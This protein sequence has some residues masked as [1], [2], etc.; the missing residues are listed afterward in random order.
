MKRAFTLLALLFVT[1]PVTTGVSLSADA[2]PAPPETPAPSSGQPSPPSLFGILTGSRW[3]YGARYKRES[4]TPVKNPN[5]RPEPQPLRDHPF[6]LVVSGDGTKVYVGLQGSELQPGHEVAVYGVQDGRVIKRIALRP[7]GETGPAGSSPYRLTLHP[8]GRFIV[9]TNRYSNFASV[10]DTET[11]EV[12]SEIPLDFYCQGMVFDR[13]G[14]RAYVTNRYLDQVFVLDIDTSGGVFSATMRVLGGVDEKTFFRHGPGGENINGLLVRR[15]GTAKCHDTLRGAFV[16][17]PEARK[18]FVSA[19]EHINTFRPEESRLL[20]APAARELGGYGDAPADFVRHGGGVVF[21]DP[22]DPDYRRLAEWIKASRPGP[23]IPV[24]NPRSKPKV[25]A[26]DSTGRYLYVGNTGTQDISVVDTET[27]QEVGGIYVQNVVNDLAVFRDPARNRDFLFVTSEGVGFGVVRERDP[28]GGETWDEENP[29]AQFSLWRDTWSGGL[30]Y[31]RTG[32][33]LPRKDQDVLGPFDAVDGTAAIKFRDIQNDLVAIDLSALPIPRADLEPQ[34]NGRSSNRINSFADRAEVAGKESHATG[35]ELDYLLKA[36]RYE[37][38]Q[39]WVRYTSDTAESTF[40]DMK[41]DIP[42]DLMRVAGAVPEKIARI[43]NRLYVSMQASAEVQTWTIRP[44]AMVP[45]G[46]PSDVLE[47]GP[48]YR[49]GLMPTGITAGRPNTPSDGLLFT[50]NFLGGSISVI[51]TRSGASREVVVDPSVR[52]R[53]VPATNAERGELFAHSAFWSSDG[54]TA[55]FHCHYLD[56]GDGRPWGVSQVLG[57]EFLSPDPEASGQLVIGGTMGVP[58]MRGLFAIQPFFFEGVISAFEPRS[59]IMEHCPADDFMGPT[60][61]GDYTNIRAQY[62]LLGIDDVQSS[63]DTSTAFKW[64]LEERRDSFFRDQSL[65]YLGRSAVLRDFQRFVGEWQINEPR[66]LPNPFDRGRLSVRRGEKLFNHPQVGCAS[67]HPP[68]NFA[69]KDFP[70]NP[71]QAMPPMVALTVRDASFTLVGMNRLDSANGYRRD[72]EPWDRGRA[73]ENQ[74]HF[75]P[76]QL[77]G[78]WD[79]PPVFLH[80]GMARTLREVLATP[81]HPA[82]GRFKYPVLIGGVPERPGRREVGFN[83]TFLFSSPINRVKGHLGAKA[84]LGVDTHGGTIHLRGRDVDDLVD[85]MQ[86]I[87]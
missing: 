13:T 75:T 20:R 4:L 45:G 14:R 47:P 42:P 1:A 80:N 38:H 17:G 30:R 48:V 35:P 78:I 46:E 7:T 85:F 72:L 52:A 83:E 10:I 60:P 86:A 49:T 40:G 70:E 54:D 82:L 51:D 61:Q 67:C 9:V 62:I 74:G 81:G 77:R 43:E 28:Y 65:R 24:G 8:G 69:R 84:R 32:R 59:M 18:T 56:M 33:V 66:L 63:M 12:V 27:L 50:A 3:A 44:E 58:Q 11:D 37:A 22:N 6:D 21:D 34:P 71:Q 39:G 64:D 29:A 23:G 19:L 68:P 76:F 25:A 79:R 55:C 16:A 41:G 2:T 87:E 5:P 36:N 31:Q 57:Q 73:E 26:L 15:C 53:P